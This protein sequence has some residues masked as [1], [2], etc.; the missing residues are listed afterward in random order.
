ME[1]SI[2]LEEGADRAYPTVVWLGQSRSPCVRSVTVCGVTVTG[3]VG[4]GACDPWPWSPLAAGR[5]PP[6][7]AELRLLWLWPMNH[8]EITHD[9]PLWIYILYRPGLYQYTAPQSK[10]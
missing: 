8:E 6:W 4:V 3:S 7:F 10:K 5:W 2:L 1:T 9:I